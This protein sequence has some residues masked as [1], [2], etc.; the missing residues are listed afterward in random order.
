MTGLA[1]GRSGPAGSESDPSPHALPGVC[2]VSSHTQCRS[3]V[4]GSLALSVDLVSSSPAAAAAA[5]S[6]HCQWASESIDLRLL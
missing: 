5:G 3:A 4:S 1:A 2:Q 6:L